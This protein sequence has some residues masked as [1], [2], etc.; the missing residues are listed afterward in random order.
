MRVH[1]RT[2]PP[3]WLNV[4]KIRHG[5]VLDYSG[6]MCTRRDRQISRR[7]ACTSTEKRRMH[8]V[9]V[10]LSTP[11][12]PDPV[13]PRPHTAGTQVRHPRCRRHGWLRM[14][15]VNER[16]VVVAVVGTSPSRVDHSSTNATPVSHT[17]P[18]NRSRFF[19][20]VAMQLGDSFRLPP[21]LCI[22]LMFSVNLITTLVFLHVKHFVLH[23]TDLSRPFYKRHRH[24][25]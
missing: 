24:R 22:M 11:R 21:V 9:V 4:A 20:L 15:D 14:R 6:D 3:V 12:G 17:V 18:S 1:N 16:L 19:R 5:R 7:V 13:R 2:V 25:L 23:E 8:A 10:G